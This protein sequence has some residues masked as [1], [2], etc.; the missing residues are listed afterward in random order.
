MTKN[1][2]TEKER[3][4]TT[5]DLDE[6]KSFLIEYQVT[7]LNDTQTKVKDFFSPLFVDIQ[8]R[9]VV[10]EGESRDRFD[11]HEKR[12]QALEAR[13]E[14]KVVKWIRVNMWKIYLALVLILTGVYFFIKHKT[15]L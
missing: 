1:L 2:K 14:T 10:N 11:D 12:I 15:K 7:I 8:R 5:K 13:D 3:P 4:L 9:I 6:L